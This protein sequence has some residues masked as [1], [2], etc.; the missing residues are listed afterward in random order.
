MSANNAKP[1]M[2]IAATSKVRPRYGEMR[3]AWR[4]R[5]GKKLNGFIG[6]SK[7]HKQIKTTAYRPR[8]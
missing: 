5:D 1:T 3:A 7:L 2:Q 6:R 4:M 8:G